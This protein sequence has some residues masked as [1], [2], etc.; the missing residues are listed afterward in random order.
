MPTQD[1]IYKITYVVKYRG[2]YVKNVKYFDTRDEAKYFLKKHS[3]ATLTSPT[4]K[5]RIVGF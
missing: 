1:F 2:R 4:R 3:T 5:E